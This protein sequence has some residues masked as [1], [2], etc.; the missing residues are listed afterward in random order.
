MDYQVSQA[1]LDFT[2]RYQQHWQ[3]VAGHAP[4]SRALYGVPSPCVI[5]QDDGEVYWRPCPPPEGLTLAGVGRALGLRLQPAVEAFYCS[6]LAGDMAARFQGRRLELL[7]IWS[8]R[9][10][11]RMQENLIGHLVMQR[12]LKLSPTLFIASTESE[13]TL[14]S[15]CNLTGQVL[16]EEVGRKKRQ[17][18]ADNLHDFLAML[19]PETA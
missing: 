14:I 3:S 19:I 18:L 1:L 11:I 4:A 15:L 13:Q 2:R 17:S 5:A 9:D 16:L 12:R 10:G 6:Q 8:E 7:Q